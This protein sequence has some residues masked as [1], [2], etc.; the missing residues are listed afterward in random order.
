MNFQDKIGIMVGK[1]LKAKISN[2]LET[3]MKIILTAAGFILLFIAIGFLVSWPVMKLWN[4]CLV[5]AVVGI[6]VITWK[7]AWGIL[8]LTSLLFKVSGSNSSSKDSK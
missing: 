2:N 4:G 1:F 3:G 8:V 7:Q 6:H 5:P